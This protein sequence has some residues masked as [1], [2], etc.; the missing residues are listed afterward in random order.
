MR[1]R[2]QRLTR[3]AAA[4]HSRTLR[5]AYAVAA[6]AGLRAVA[7]LGEVARHC[8]TR[9][10][11]NDAGDR[12]ERSLQPGSGTWDVVLGTAYVYTP[13]DGAR[14]WF[15]Q[16]ERQ[17]A[18][19]EREDYR[20]GS[21]LTVTGGV[22]FQPHARVSWIVQATAQLRG[23]DRGADAEPRDSGSRAVFVSPGAALR[24]ARSASAY[25]LLQVPLYQHVNGVQIT[26]DQ[27]LILGVSINY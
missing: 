3:E 1:F 17:Y 11:C 24:L 5:P 10:G 8:A 6:G 14:S 13:P 26:A 18:V 25:A 19:N 23:R 27:A 9:A 2:V 20:P 7:E 4:P 16:G 12:A 15:A 21:Q 22:N